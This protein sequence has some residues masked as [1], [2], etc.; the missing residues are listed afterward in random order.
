M[1]AAFQPT[2]LRSGQQVPIA[3]APS[4]RPLCGNC[5]LP[6]SRRRDR[7]T[8]RTQG[9]ERLASGAQNAEHCFASCRRLCRQPFGGGGDDRLGH[10]PAAGAHARQ[11]QRGVGVCR[12]GA[13]SSATRR[14]TKPVHSR[15]W[16]NA[17]GRGTRPCR[18]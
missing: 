11:S 14:A 18:P 6:R 15:R 1:F 7:Q 10:V 16:P 3:L 13:R 2:K 12:H 8:R 9:Q 17:R 5:V 4:G